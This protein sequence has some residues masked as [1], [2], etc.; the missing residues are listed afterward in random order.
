[1]VPSSATNLHCRADIEGARQRQPGRQ[2]DRHTDK[3]SDWQ[4]Q[5]DTQTNEVIE[6]QYTDMDMTWRETIDLA[7]DR[8]GWRDCVS[9]C[10]DL[11]KKD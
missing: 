4:I 2:A 8:E 11:H 10:A 1:M 5:A 3:L 9:R 7:E 6:G